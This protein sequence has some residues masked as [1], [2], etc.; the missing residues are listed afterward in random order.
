MKLLI[1]SSTAFKS[2][3]GSESGG[4]GGSLFLLTA[5]ALVVGGGGG[6]RGWGALVLGEGIV[7]A[8]DELTVP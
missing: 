1:T 2:V 8:S 4:G 5:T 3:D 7:D 6:D